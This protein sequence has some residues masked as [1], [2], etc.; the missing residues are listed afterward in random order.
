MTGASPSILRAGIA[1][2]IL[3]VGILLGRPADP[4][5]SLA[6]SGT[7][8]SFSNAYTVMDIAFELSFAATA[9]VLA[10]SAW[11][12][13]LRRDHP[14]QGTLTQM[15]MDLTE[16][17]AIS[18]FASLFTLPVLVLQGMSLST[19]SV[20]TNLL[21]LW[22]IAPILICGFGAALFGFWNGTKF[23]QYAFSL[24]GGLLVQLLNRAVHVFAALPFAR[25]SFRM[26]LGW[27]GQEG[28]ERCITIVTEDKRG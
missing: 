17:A 18:G 14:P 20:L 13:R 23:L 21:T 24:P 5:T 27:T 6:V 28:K 7:M 11:M 12:R 19:V 4:L 2:L 26:Q 1:V 22:L 10:A 16:S 8:M 15:G 25:R 9:G 3:N